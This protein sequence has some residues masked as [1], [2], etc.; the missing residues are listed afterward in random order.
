MK[1][2]KC[3]FTSFGFLD[4]CKRC[5]YLF[6]EEELG[7]KG[8]SFT[9]PLTKEKK[10]EKKEAKPGLLAKIKGN[11]SR[12]VAEKEY[13]RKQKKK[14]K[15]DA[16]EKNEADAAR[17]NADTAVNDL[18]EEVFD[19]Q[20]D[21]LFGDNKDE[22]KGDGSDSIKIT[23][24]DRFSESQKEAEEGI[25]DFGYE[26]SF[27]NVTSTPDD[28]AEELFKES[29]PVTIADVEDESL[30]GAPEESKVMSFDDT[31]LGEA[32]VNSE[33]E[34]FL[35]DFIGAD[36]SAPTA[37]IKA[38]DKKTGDDAEINYEAESFL[39]DFIGIDEELTEEESKPEEKDDSK[40]SL[41]VDEDFEVLHFEIVEN[42][43]DEKK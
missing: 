1:C 3:G 7:S 8:D 17:V 21:G 15:E 33:A 41:E 38:D 6:T 36:D 31:T 22:I 16:R 11:I 35:T 28:E 34:D 23:A 27:Y 25:E 5:G 14:K 30:L 43:E 13:A 29:E 18:S 12:K 20:F 19:E 2:P 4:K 9:V 10:K 32:D 42:D 37:E 40:L 26:E 24:V 39:S